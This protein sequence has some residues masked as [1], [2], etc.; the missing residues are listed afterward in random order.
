[1]NKIVTILHEIS[2]LES[3]NSIN[4]LVEICYKI[5]LS[6]LRFNYKKIHQIASREELSLEDLAIDSIASLFEKDESGSFHNLINPFNSWQPPIKS[7]EEALYFLDKLIQKRVEQH[8][9]FLLREA[10]PF[11]SKLMDSVNYLIK[12]LNH[13]KVNYLGT[14]FIVYSAET[15][16]IFGKT[17]PFEEF[18]K[19]PAKLFTERKN[20]LQ[21]IFKYLVSE[22]NY[23]S[24]IPFNALVYKLK[25]LN[26]TLYNVSESTTEQNDGIEVESIITEA[27]NKTFK[28]LEDSYLVKEKLTKVESEKIRK[29]LINMAQDLKDGGVNPGL[30]KYL[31]AHYDELDENTYKQ[32]YHNILE[33]LLKVLK[34]NIAD[35][36]KQ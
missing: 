13:K 34:Q 4:K 2:T 30:Y 20:L 28:K 23:I 29:A 33:Y 19:L 21:N 25:E 35:E 14:V 31:L 22:T 36:L 17:I 16:E 11:F 27:L 15:E 24:A 6:N 18:E 7:E 26:V 32:K 8:I 5:A 1:M 3:Q 9:S 10:D 12:K